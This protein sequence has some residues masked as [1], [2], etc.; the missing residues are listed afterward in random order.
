MYCSHCGSA[1]PEGSALCTQCGVKIETPVPPAP[2]PEPSIP[3]SPAP[4]VP[5]IGAAFSAPAADAVPT[6][7]RFPNMAEPP[8]AAPGESAPPPRKRSRKRLIFSL[9][10]AVLVLAL[11]AGGMVYAFVLNTPEAKLLRALENTGEELE[12]VFEHCKNLN[13]VVE[14]GKELYESG[15]LSYACE[16]TSDID[17]EPVSFS[18]RADI[19]RQQK[20][21]GGSVDFNFGSTIPTIQ[22]QFYLNEESLALGLPQLLDDVYS[23]PMK[24]FG[25]KL[26]A[27]PLAKLAEIEDS[28]IISD[29]SFNCFAETD[30]DDFRKQY[31]EEASAFLDSIRI[32]ETDEAIPKAERGLEAYS[33]RV[34][35]QCAD[36]LLKAYME[37]T[38]RTV[39]GTD[40]MLTQDVFDDMEDTF[41]ALEDEA[42]YLLIGINDDNCISAVCLTDE[43]QEYVAVLL[44]EG[45]Q[46]LWNDVTLLVNGKTVAA[47]SLQSTADGFRCE[48]EAE[49]TAFE[50]VCEDAEGLISVV[51]GA[52]ET[53]ALR[54]ESA[55]GGLHVY[56]VSPDEVSRFDLRLLPLQQ[57]DKLSDEPIDLF[58]AST[59]KLQGIVMEIYSNLQSLIP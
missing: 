18:L 4:V 47:V 44:L 34:D 59:A 31:P 33:L 35:W 5:P 16:V 6:F 23:I 15:K 9:I 27:S 50:V 53:P 57:I 25:K 1:L 43:D 20:Q 54:Y 3:E 39:Y 40:A 56:A 32:E 13:A 24:D 26:L 8:F 45:R 49:D 21:L 42:F 36:E 55:D 22:M 28:D 37:Y 41:A 19:D 14:C 12:E 29:L 2:T 7:D 17:Y 11:L 30:W 46:N 52:S 51:D 48:I 58:S 10:A 38:V